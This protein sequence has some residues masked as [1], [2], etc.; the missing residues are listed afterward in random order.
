MTI[1]NRHRDAQF[2]CFFLVLF[3]PTVA[4][5]WA[6]LALET[7]TA[8]VWEPGQFE[9]STAVNSAKLFRTGVTFKF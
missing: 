4:N 3:I 9:I 6:D 5:G 8:R 2:R 1:P 7:E